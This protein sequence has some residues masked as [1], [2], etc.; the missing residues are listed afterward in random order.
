MLGLYTT[1]TFIEIITRSSVVLT[2]FESIDWFSEIYKFTLFVWLSWKLFLFLSAELDGLYDTLC[3]PKSTT[4]SRNV[5]TTCLIVTAF[6]FADTCIVVHRFFFTN[7]VVYNEQGGKKS[8]AMEMWI[9]WMWMRIS[10]IE[11]KNNLV[12][13]NQIRWKHDFV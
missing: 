3:L 1:L 12:V 6:D 8:N 7:F 4:K 11:S 10:C 13:L 2:S 5:A 9:R